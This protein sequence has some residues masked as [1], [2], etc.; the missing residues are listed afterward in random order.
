MPHTKQFSGPTLN[1]S[2]RDLL[3]S[4]GSERS[5]KDYKTNENIYVQGET[6]DT[7]FFIQQGRVKITVVS[8][9]RKLAVVGILHEGQFFGEGC[10]H[11][12]AVRT[13]TSVALCPCRITSR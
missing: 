9:Q 2:P 7:V 1:A 10:L 5:T 8:E 4:S 3:V 13:A 6:A 11:G 12:Q